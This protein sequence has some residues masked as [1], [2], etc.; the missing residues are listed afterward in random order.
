MRNGWI[1]VMYCDG[2]QRTFDGGTVGSRCG[3][4]EAGILQERNVRRTL[5]V[6]KKIGELKS[7]ESSLKRELHNL[8]I[9]IKELED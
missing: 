4:C 5:Q 1:K 9:E 6:Q 7:K 3:C 8:Q 2:C